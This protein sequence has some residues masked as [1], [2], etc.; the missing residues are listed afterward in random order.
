[1]PAITEATLEM[2]FHSALMSLFRETYGLGPTGSIEFFKYSP[3]L[4]K[5]IGFDQAYVKTE[6][7]EKQLFKELSD[8][9]SNSSYKT[10]KI[11]IGY[12]LQFKV[13]KQLIR[14]SS[15]MPAG[16]YAPYL[17]VD[18]DTQRRATNDP[19]QHELL[20]SLASNPGAMVYYA[21]PMLFDRV[22]LYRPEA[23]LDQ[24]VLADLRSAP[25]PYTDNERHFIC[26]QHQSSTPTW[27]STPTEGDRINAQEF[28]KKLAE[29]AR[30]PDLGT[31]NRVHIL[32]SLKTAINSQFGRDE[33]IL[34][35]L[36]DSLT[37]LAITPH[38]EAA[39]D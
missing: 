35:H 20:Y 12:F 23:D 6:M 31:V 10:K 2:H 24:L 25:A 34:E 3:Q 29:I 26:Y 38:D 5:F 32:G 7:S 21:C 14:R 27:C 28:V 8:A 37:I 22:E 36:V 1:M 11:L 16:F 9:A 13:V 19:S 15:S 17:R 33:R 30:S 39:Q 4:E 18:I